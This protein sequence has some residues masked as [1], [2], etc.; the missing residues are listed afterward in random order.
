MLELR[1]VSVSYGEAIALREVSLSVPAGSMVALIGSNGAGKTTLVH[2]LMGMLK[3]RAGQI[4]FD[5]QDIQSTAAHERPALGLALVPEGRRLIPGMSVKENLLLGTHHKAARR[6]SQGG[7]EWVLDLFPVLRDRRQQLAGTMSGGEQQMVALGRALVGRPQVL[8]L[9][10]PSLGL[11]P[12]IVAQVFDLIERV[13]AEGVTVLIAEQNVQQTLR[14]SDYGYVLEEG[15][16]VLHANAD[17]LIQSPQV[18]A[19]YLG[20]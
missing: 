8:I 16:V 19:A 15:Q 12:V 3:P 20:E 5:G 4:L 10:E 1:D 17:E 11:A 2:T 13:R 14:L 7:L 9:D 18:R 6:R